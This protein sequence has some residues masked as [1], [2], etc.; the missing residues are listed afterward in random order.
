MLFI[1]Q[2]KTMKQICIVIRV[3]DRIDDLEVNL[4]IIRNTWKKNNYYIIVT[5]NGKLN[6]YELTDKIYQNADY[7][8]EINHNLG[9]LKGNSQLLL[10]SIKFIPKECEYTVLLEAD[11][12]IYSDKLLDFYIQKLFIQN[13]IWASANWYDR[14]KS[15]ATDFAIVN[16]N[17]LLQNDQ[18]LNFTEYPECWVTN[19]LIDHN[20]KILYIRELMPVQIASYIKKLPYAPFGRFYV[21]PLGK[22]VTHHVEDL[23]GGIDEKKFFF[24]V[25]A[26]TT[27]FSTVMNKNKRVELFKIY[28]IHFISHL[29]IRRSWYSKRKRYIFH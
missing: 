1:K 9:H 27:Y 19:Y 28:L 15:N 14:F 13:A 4:D 6:G 8:L 5:S 22:M 21:F 11:T 18:L 23:R 3:Y 12:W 16:T 7:V 25:I 20:A 2:L 17:F 10:E 26:G 29:L 24:N